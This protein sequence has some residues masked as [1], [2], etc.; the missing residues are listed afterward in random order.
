[1][2]KTID[3]SDNSRVY[4][5][6]SQ[7]GIN[8]KQARVYLAI[9]RLGKSKVGEIAK[10]A[11]EIRTTTYHHLDYLESRGLITATR[12]GKQTHYLANKPK[13]LTQIL[14]D[15][16]KAINYLIPRLKQVA[17]DVAVPKIEMFEGQDIIQLLNRVLNC[18]DRKIYGI[19]R[20]GLI[21]EA[22][23]RSFHFHKKRAEKG[24]LAKML[25]PRQNIRTIDQLRQRQTIDLMEI[26]LLPEEIHP[27][28]RMI[29]FDQSVALLSPRE[30]F[31]I[32]INSKKTHEMWMSLFEMLWGVSKKI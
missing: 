8:D 27:D 6:L 4:E 10:L 14:G 13:V 19:W 28:I 2:S 9:L 18:R 24:I 32:I 3:I 11:Q 31:G 29:L 15:Q 12:S 30:G 23:G 25:Y 7:L 22:R 1:M 17:K 20:E 21:K 5:A 16:Q 26:K